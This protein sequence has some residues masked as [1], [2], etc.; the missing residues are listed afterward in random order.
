MTSPEHPQ[1][2]NLTNPCQTQRINGM[3]VDMHKLAEA[4]DKLGAQA[5]DVLSIGGYR[6]ARGQLVPDYDSVRIER[7]AQ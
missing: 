5:S 1:L 6:N 4:A 2:V 7:R 3:T